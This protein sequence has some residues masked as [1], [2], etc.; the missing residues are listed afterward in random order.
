MFLNSKDY[1]FTKYR[2]RRTVRFFIH[3]KMYKRI[4]DKSDYDIIIYIIGF[5]RCASN[6]FC[7]INSEWIFSM[8]Y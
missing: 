5:Q 2:R 7:Y 3:N 4:S 1:D 8:Q 6:L